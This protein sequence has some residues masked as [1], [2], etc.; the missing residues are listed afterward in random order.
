MRE[1][2]TIRKYDSKTYKG[3]LDIQGFDAGKDIA[4]RGRPA[5]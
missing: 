5:A 1:R 3:D 4:G 2:R